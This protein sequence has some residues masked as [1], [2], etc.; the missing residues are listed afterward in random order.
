MTASII[1]ADSHF[2]EPPEMWVERIDPAY[3]DRAPRLASEVDGQRG[4][5]LVCEGL[6]PA[7]GGGYFAAGTAPE[8]L[9]EVLARGYD[10]VPPHVRDPAARVTEQ[11][12]DGVLAEVLYSSY[13]M[14]LFHL[15]D[16]GLRDA[17]FRAFNDW[18]ADY[19]SED[20]SRLIGTGLVALDDIAV[21]T[22][23]LRRIAKKGLRGAMIWAE[24]PAER[25]YSHPDYEPFFA[26][27]QELD[28]KLSLHSLT[29]R[30]KDSDPAKGDM[31]FRAVILYQEVARTISDLI[32]HGVCEKFP[33]LTFVS[34][35]NEIA[36]AVARAIGMPGALQTDLFADGRAEMVEF[37]VHADAAENIVGRRIAEL[38]VPDESV[39]ASLIRAD[40]VIIPGGGDIV[41]EGDRIV[42]IA[43]PE[44]SREWSVRLA[45]R[46]L[47][48]IRE[49]VVV[50][51][52]TTGRTIARALCAQRLRVRIVDADQAVARI[53][54]EEISEA[55]VFCADA[56]DTAFLQR[57]NIGHA[58][59][60]ICCTERDERDLLIAL[61]AKSLGVRI[62]IAVVG[63]PDYVPIFERVG[64]DHAL[65]Q[66]LVVAEEIVRFTHDPRTRG[67]AMLENDRVEVL[68]LEI[69]P[70]S[71]LI[72]RPFRERPLEGAI[73][74]AIVRGDRVIFP[75]GDDA[76]QAGDSAIILAEAQ[77]VAALEQAL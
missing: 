2:V 52:G 66:R 14:Q 67:F 35:E 77:R 38:R 63:D 57:E 1:S 65:N 70:E 43:S 39:I 25:P 3:R 27:A 74:G 71:S 34:A 45:R 44:A 55:D 24:P 5:F 51:G 16:G 15:D 7:S 56:T 11:K 42:L 36:Q 69:R 49:V 31:L 21:A 53:C 28:M 8:D 60:I 68:E 9:P 47:A 12:K 61:L 30:R 48:A 72:G 32:L 26:V 59:A 75:R 18:A 40:D 19:C 62:A 22:E 33:S 10:A 17:C 50:G 46:D 76:L 20:P 4:A 41:Q 13:G 54:A 64:V 23:E 6:V 29:S 58:D 73:V 37:E